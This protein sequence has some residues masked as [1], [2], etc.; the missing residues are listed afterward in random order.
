MSA[1]EYFIG[2]EFMLKILRYMS[3]HAIHVKENKDE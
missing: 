1:Q 3:I 2:K